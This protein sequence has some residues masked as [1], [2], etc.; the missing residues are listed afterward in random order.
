MRSRRS[1]IVTLVLALLFPAILRATEP[2]PRDERNKT[3]TLSNGV[4]W[5]YRQHDNPPGK[6]AL[7]LHVRSGSLN[8][9]DAQRGLAHF[10]EHMCFNGTENFPP[11]KLVPYFESIGMEFGADLNA[12]TSFDQTQYQ[13]TLPDTKTEELDKALMVLSDYAFRCTFEP[14]EIDDERGVI[15]A[16]KRA[17]ENVAERIRDKLWPELYAGSHFAQRLPIGT[18]EVISNAGRNEFLDY[19]RTWYRPE[20]ITVMLV[21]DAEIERVTPLIEKWFGAYKS[22]LPARPQQSAGFKPFETER[23]IIVSEPQM[24]ICNLTIYNM[25]PGREPTT[26]VEQFR[27]DLVEGI[28]GWI[29]QR[30]C[31]DR[32]KK[33][34]ADFQSA[35]AGVSRFFRDAVLATAVASG[36]PEKWENML[37]QLIEELNRARQFGFTARELELARKEFLAEAERSVRTEPSRN[38]GAI[39]AEI[40]EG[41]NECEPVMSAQQELELMQKLLPTITPE[42][43]S[44]AFAASFAPGRYTYVMTTDDRPDLKNPTRDDLLAAARAAM[45]R[46]VTPLAEERREKE[47]LVQPPIP[48]ST[49]DRRFDEDLQITTSLLSNGVRVHHRF[50]DYKKDQV[51]VSITLAGGQIEETPENAGITEV[52]ALVLGQKATRRLPSTDITDLMTGKNI[53]VGGGASGD[54]FTLRISG[55]PRDLEEGLKLAHALLTEGKIEQSAFD[56]WRE[57]AVQRLE[58]LASF[59]EFIAQKAL[60]ESL[61]GNDPRLTLPDRERIARQSLEA[62]QAWFDRLREKAPIEIAVVGELPVEKSG[63]LMET[64]F[65]SLPRRPKYAETLEPLRVVKRPPGPLDVKAAVETRSDKAMVITGFVGA[66]AR[67]VDDDRALELASNI[68]SSRLIKRVREELALVYSL[69]A[70]HRASAVYRD[71]GTFLT[72]AACAPEKSAAV[73][74]E[75]EKIYAAFAETGPTDEELA[76]AKKQIL[77]N[78]DVQT[79][80]PGYWLGVLATLELH[81]RTL[82]DQ[83]RVKAAFEAATAEQVKNTFRKYYRL[84]RIFRVVALPAKPESAS[85]GSSEKK[86]EPAAP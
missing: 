11:G 81:H 7:T 10:I 37:D 40:A 3:G 84:D 44:T 36:P 63:P 86:P 9:S 55:S 83:K 69:S 74:E 28:G 42:D 18:E 32:V 75:I 38:A 30:R 43:V 76:N 13:L 2:L 1:A 49:T 20:N 31:S 46:S 79:R 41:V 45:V 26:T 4:T 71:M 85:A 62:A 82:D 25:L 23:A 51:F 12:F 16:E 15:L 53:Q 33:G 50:M 59:P 39:L 19:Y 34:L 68:L 60:I 65:G 21:G 67:E 14:K 57:G 52:A 48:G 58:L 24:S 22:D 17:R 27:R 73:V 61:S 29:M 64:Y 66:D 6:M 77:N 47:L 35:G 72:G 8:E 5:V 54:A 78:L 70:S 80:E 56:K